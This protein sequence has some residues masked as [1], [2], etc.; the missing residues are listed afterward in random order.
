MLQMSQ[1][2]DVIGRAIIET[3]ENRKTGVKET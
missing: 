1:P 2:H 3:K